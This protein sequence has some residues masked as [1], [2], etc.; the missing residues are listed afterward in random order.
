M[1]LCKKLHEMPS[2]L[3]GWQQM[4]WCPDCDY[5]DRGTCGYPI[6]TDSS[7]AC[8]FDGRALPLREVAVDPNNEP[9]Q[10]SRDGAPRKGRESQPQSMALESA[11]LRQIVQRTGGRIQM[12]EVEMLNDLVVVR[13]CVPSYHVKQPVLQGVPDVIGSARATGVELN[14]QV[15]GSTATSG[16]DAQ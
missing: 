1:S 13:G 7:A 2:V 9:P 8:P 6:R 5:Y 15:L 11:I 12:L 4:T 16:S 14:L 3:T 10:K